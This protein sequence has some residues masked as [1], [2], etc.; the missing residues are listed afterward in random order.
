MAKLT[1][2]ISDEEFNWLNI[3]AKTQ[4]LT[5]TQIVRAALHQVLEDAFVDRIP[6][7]L[8]QEQYQALVDFEGKPLTAEEIEG[9]K[10]LAEVQEWEL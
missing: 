5:K 8:P 7:R 2:Q 6:F 10:R 4:G 3:L 1:I 9:R